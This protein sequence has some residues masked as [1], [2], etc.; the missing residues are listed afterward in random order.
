MEKNKLFIVFLMMLMVVFLFGC[1]N[2]KAIDAESIQ[3]TGEQSGE[4]GQSISLATAVTP[5]G[6]TI[7]DIN[8][9]SDDETIATV[10]NSGVVSLLAPGTV[11]ITATMGDI[12]SEF[13]IVVSESI[14]VS[15]I[16]NENL[17]VGETCQLTGVTNSTDSIVWTSSNEDLATVDDNGLV[18]ALAVGIAEINAAVEGNLAHVTIEIRAK[19]ITYTLAVSG[20]ADGFVGDTLALTADTNSTDTLVWTSSD[21]TIAT[22]N[23]LGE[24]ILVAAGSVTITATVGEL[25]DSIEITVSEVVETGPIFIYIDIIFMEYDDGDIVSYDGKTLTVGTDAFALSAF[26]LSSA[27]DGDTV[28]F[29]SGI[30]AENIVV[31]KELTL[32]GANYNVNPNTDTRVDG[33]ILQGDVKVNANNVTV[34]GFNISNS[35]IVASDEG[36]DNISVINNVF[37]DDFTFNL[38][39]KGQIELLTDDTSVFFN[40]VTVSYNLFKANSGQRNTKIVA[41]QVKDFTAEGNIMYGASQ[42]IY[43]DCFKF[44]TPTGYSTIGIQGEV[45]VENNKFYDIG[46]Y[47][48]WF[49]TYS[50]GKYEIYNNYFENVGKT[51]ADGSTSYWR[52]ALTM[53]SPTAIE[54]GVEINFMG[55]EINGS[56]GGIRLPNGSL[57]TAQ[58]VA[59]V[60]NNIFE[61]ILQSEIIITESPSNVSD[62]SA[63]ALVIDAKNNYYDV[64]VDDSM[65]YG[66]SDY[67]T[68]YTNKE[69]VP[70]HVSTD[71]VLPTSITINNTEEQIIST[72]TL[73]LDVVLDSEATYTALVYTSSDEN[74]V[75]V[76]KGGLVSVVG[77]GTV[78][79]TVSSK[80][81][82]TIN[83]TYE[84][85]A[86][87]FEV[88][89]P[90]YEMTKDS[91]Y[92]IV[93]NILPDETANQIVSYTSSDSAIATVS[94][95]GLVT[96]VAAGIVDIAIVSNYYTGVEINL[97]LEVNDVSEAEVNAKIDSL[98]SL[99][100]T[101]NVSTV[102]HNS[103][104]QEIG[105]QATYTVDLYGSVNKFYFGDKSINTSI[106]TPLTNENRPGTKKTSIE[107]I[108]IHDTGST[109]ASAGAASHA[110]YVQNPSTATSWSYTVGNDGIY[111]QI[112]EDEVTYHA[113]DGTRPFAL[114]AS[115]VSVTI[116]ASESVVA[117]NSNGYYTI[118]GVE[119][120]L[121]PYKIVDGVESLDMTNY[122]TAQIVD[123]GIHIE[124]QDGQYYLGKTWYSSTYNRVGNYGGNRNS[125]GIET[126]VNNGSN[127]WQTWHMVSYLTASLALKYDLPLSRVVNHHF[128]SGKDCPQTM[129]TAGYWDDVMLLVA[130]EYAV[131]KDYS[132]CQVT[133][134]S[135]NPD[136]VNNSGLVI[137]S[138]TVDTT[139][140]YTIT[141]SNSGISKSVTLSSL[142]PADN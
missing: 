117:L 97:E 127:L 64:A 5:E 7:S 48:I 90:Q 25:S 11:K 118:N 69:Q 2:N 104:V 101:Y 133:M 105:Y 50:D 109:A 17:Q 39:T 16:G 37:E 63:L 31:N 3:I 12:S 95:T 94:E 24:V 86:I 38:N 55:N 92:Q 18:T 57:T 126:C 43:D 113:G 10:S 66:V 122:T 106:T 41:T 72:E 46:Q 79:I 102:E 91:T 21:S 59:K 28:Y 51:E 53:N 35:Q 49:R 22:V 23:E 96:S 123:M 52:G 75:T 137:G 129:R 65:F 73:Q 136:L 40:N 132:D 130:A 56:N 116:S 107:Y 128:F 120:T 77:P 103:N 112:P 67:S 100:S 119:T 125:I 47:T 78:T 27:K 4:V 121:R 62:K 70:A 140:S 115:G 84:L 42:G 108:C 36:V 15:I 93:M 135:G 68:T 98:L 89:D 138:P 87:V 1:E 80:A 141:V 114:E 44:Y 58:F 99:L 142:V 71:E 81:D 14:V 61:G 82:S 19:E 76:S 139:V 88:S 74:I 110:S 131:A 124:E 6:A 111:F 60:N 29:A 83:N 30:Y 33:T 54:N 85:K 45:L 9:S 34:N 26:A 13:E 134:E 32:L 8:W 20:D